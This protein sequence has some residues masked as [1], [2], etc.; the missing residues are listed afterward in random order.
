MEEGIE[1]KMIAHQEKQV[2]RNQDTVLGWVGKEPSI[3]QENLG[4]RASAK[5]I[6]TLLSGYC[7]S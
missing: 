7:D 1:V 4:L 6:T 2:Y 3:T 5:G